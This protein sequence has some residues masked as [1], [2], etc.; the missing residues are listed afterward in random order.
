MANINAD[1]AG[2]ALDNLAQVLIPLS[3]QF[4]LYVTS[5]LFFFFSNILKGY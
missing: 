1:S 2:S 4:I 5:R 3:R